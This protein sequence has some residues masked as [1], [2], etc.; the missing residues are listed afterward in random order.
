MGPDRVMGVC[1][2]T[3]LLYESATRLKFTFS[4]IHAAGACQARYNCPQS[5]SAA[6]SLAVPAFRKKRASTAPSPGGPFVWSCAKGTGL[7]ARSGCPPRRQPTSS[8]G[9]RARRGLAR[10]RAAAWW[11]RVTRPCHGHR[12]GHRQAEPGRAAAAA[13]ARSALSAAPVSPRRCRADAPAAPAARPGA[14][15]RSR[16]A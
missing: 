13:A 6:V 11:S 3:S 14:C 4:A 16:Y 8:N 15:W 9:P 7:H 12:D 1:K 10:A 2:G 5:Y